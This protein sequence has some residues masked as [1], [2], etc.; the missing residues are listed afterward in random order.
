MRTQRYIAAALLTSLA[1]LPAGALAQSGS[2]PSRSASDYKATTT[3]G[4]DLAVCDRVTDASVVNTA[5]EDVGTIQDLIVSRSTGDIMYVV[6]KSGAILGIGGKTV[7]TPFNSFRW[8][9]ANNRYTLNMTED[10]VQALPEFNA[11]EWA[12]LHKDESGLRT[13]L[14]RQFDESDRTEKD[15]KPVAIANAQTVRGKVVAV[16]RSFYGPHGEDVILVVKTDKGAQERVLLGPSWY[17]MGANGAPMRDN[18]VTLTV[19]Q[20]DGPVAWVAVKGDVNGVKTTYRDAEGRPAWTGETA[21]GR[22]WRDRGPSA[23]LVLVSDIDGA[24]V[25][26]RG[27]SCGTVEDVIIDRRNGRALLLSIDPDENILGIGDE[28]RLVPWSVAYLGVDGVV[29]IDADKQMITSS[30]Q[31]PDSFDGYRDPATVQRVYSAF[32]V[33]MTG[34]TDPARPQP[35]D[36]MRTPQGG[37]KTTKDAEKHPG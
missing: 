7:A 31:T 19:V 36:P 9:E 33:P 35:H 34:T 11:D 5:G 3:Q 2:L 15:R 22:A 28:N 25:Q 1:G 12:T 29:N 30:V 17:V 13:W 8:D 24:D 23:R 6:L 37:D 21:E 4:F 10:Q 20:H 18:P 14:N 16:E 32:G 26:C 27:E